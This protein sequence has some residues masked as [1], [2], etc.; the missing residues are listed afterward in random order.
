V[1]YQGLVTPLLDYYRYI[2]P[3]VESTCGNTNTRVR[4]LPTTSTQL[5]LV[6]VSCGKMRFM[7]GLCVLCGP[8]FLCVCAIRFRHFR[9]GRHMES[10]KTA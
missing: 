1:A 2:I 4:Q 5:P 6:L 10:K 8:M 9:L 7:C 3:E